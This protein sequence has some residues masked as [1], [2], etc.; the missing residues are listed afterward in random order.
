MERGCE[1]GLLLPILII[2]VHCLAVMLWASWNR[3]RIS[4]IWHHFLIITVEI[5]VW[6]LS[7]IGNHYSLGAFLASP[8]IHYQPS[9][10]VR[11]Q[12]IEVLNTMWLSWKTNAAIRFTVR[13]LTVASGWNALSLCT[14]V[15]C[16]TEVGS[17]LLCLEV[18][19]TSSNWLG[20][21]G[22][23]LLRL[24]LLL[25]ICCLHILISNELIF[26]WMD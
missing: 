21:H 19:G 5:N 8:S 12:L 10:S 4:L 3:R 18:V 6:P 2:V 20:V 17:R 22:D 7:A 1:I 13:L 23:I 11:R 16:S 14:V 9:L 26:F 25:L 15:S 24:Q